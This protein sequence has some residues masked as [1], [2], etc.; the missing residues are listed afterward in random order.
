VWCSQDHPMHLKEA[1]LSSVQRKSC[2][3]VV[4]IGAKI[5]S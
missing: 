4:I 1:Y 3:F 5:R 2:E